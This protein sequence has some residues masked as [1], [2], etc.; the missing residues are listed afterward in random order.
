MYAGQYYA[1]C[2]A[3]RTAKCI[4]AISPAISCISTTLADLDKLCMTCV[5]HVLCISADYAH[6]STSHA[7]SRLDKLC[8]T[9]VC[10]VLCISADYAHTS[11][12]HALSRLAMH[13]IMLCTIC[14]LDWIESH[15]SILSSNSALPQ[16]LRSLHTG[17]HILGCGIAQDH[18]SITDRRITDRRI[19]DR[20]ITDRME[21]PKNPKHD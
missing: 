4:L 14:N 5:C 13:I 15:T 7:L 10:H 19:T 20:R 18:R 12:S 11:T 2:L 9:C 1:T 21:N 16:D 6:T 8:M 3:C 17:A